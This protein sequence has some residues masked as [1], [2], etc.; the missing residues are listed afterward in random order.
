MTSVVLEYPRDEAK[1]IIKAS[2]EQTSSID[3]YTDETQRIVCQQEAS[4]TGGNGA[5]L[6]VDI[7][8]MQENEN[9]TRIEISAEKEVA[10]DMATNPEDIKSDL[11]NNLNRIRGGDIDDIVERTA[12]SM[13]PQSSKEVSSSNEFGSNET[14]MGKRFI[15]MFVVLMGFSIIFGI[16]MTSL[17]LP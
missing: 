2:I 8:E 4:L 12:N 3:A 7:P 17:Y 15:I 13:T 9:K 14:T 5:R 6:T 10:I 1:T 16:F 11:L